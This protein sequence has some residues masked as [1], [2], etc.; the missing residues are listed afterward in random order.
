MRS[1]LRRRRLLDDRVTDRAGADDVRDDLD[2]VVLTE[3]RGPPPS[4]RLHAPERHPEA[5]PRAVYRRG[6]RTTVI[7]STVAPLSAA[8]RNRGR[9]HLLADL[10]DLHRH[11]DPPEPG[12]HRERR[13]RIDVVEDAAV[14]PPSRHPEDDEPEAEPGGPGIA[15]AR[16]GHH[17]EHERSRAVSGTPISAAI[18]TGVPRTR[19]SGPARNG[20]GRSGSREA[21][22]DHGELG[23]RE[24]DED[25]ER[26]DARKEAAR[27][28]RGCRLQDDDGDR[29]SA[30]SR[31]SPRSRR[32]SAAR[33]ARTRGEH[34]VRGHRVREPGA[35]RDRGRRRA[36]QDERAREP[37][38]DA[39]RVDEPGREARRRAR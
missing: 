31:G 32:A 17:R 34:P 35:A 36:E 5:H 21:Q 13:E 30:R 22:P 7:A 11:E 37:D 24:R 9:D 14:V 39:Q 33:S 3:E 28:L 16:V 2:A 6:T 27:R 25:A 10:A 15:R 18:G 20:R 19:M 12:A 4:P 8:M 26:V 29:G 1:A 23:E 38:H